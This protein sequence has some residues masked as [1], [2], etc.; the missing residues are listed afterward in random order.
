[1]YAE[2]EQKPLVT[3]ITK[4]ANAIGVFVAVIG[5]VFVITNLIGLTDMDWLRVVVLFVFPCA[6]FISN[7]H[8][9]RK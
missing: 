7:K 6:I 5:V 3:T 1:M 8:E 2:K 9:K 4:L